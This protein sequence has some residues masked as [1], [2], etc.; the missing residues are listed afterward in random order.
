MAIPKY[1]KHTYDEKMNNIKARPYDEIMNISDDEIKRSSKKYIQ[2]YRKLEAEFEEK[3]GLNKLDISL[4]VIAA[5][6]QCLRWSLITNSS[7]RFTSATS[8]EKFIEGFG[9]KVG[10]HFPT[11]EEIILDHQVPYDVVQ[12]SDDYKIR[13]SEYSEKEGLSAISTGIAGANHRYTTLGHDPLAGLIVGTANIATN[14]L[15][16]NDF[17]VFSSYLVVDHKIDMPISFYGDV[18]SMTKE[19]YDNNPECLGAAFIKQIIHCSTD[20]FT[21]QGLPLPIINVLSPET[22]KFLIG[23]HIDLYSVTRSVMLAILINK[24]VEMIHRLFYDKNQDDRRLYDVRT[25]KVVMYSNTLSSV[26]NL[27]YV[28]A[29]GDMDRLDIGGIAVTLWRL[30]TDVREINKIKHDFIRQSIDG[31]FQKEEDEVNERLARLGF[32]I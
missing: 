18:F 28:G 32:E 21:K 27:S 8:G 15:T 23:K 3:T 30:L 2:D 12:T 25:R 7:G 31:A 6:V 26:I 19:V 4:M 5:F 16:K 22:S 17:P 29:T 1:K 13:F 9:H 14:T 24:I 20:V 11:L 10:R